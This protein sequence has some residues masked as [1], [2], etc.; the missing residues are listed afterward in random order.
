MYNILYGQ[1]QKI[2]VGSCIIKK[3]SKNVIVLHGFEL[4][5]YLNH[6]R[7]FWILKVFFCETLIFVFNLYL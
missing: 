2:T 1:I 3:N 6:N 4:K 7:Y 5:P